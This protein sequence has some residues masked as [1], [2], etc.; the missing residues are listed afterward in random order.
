MMEPND[1]NHAVSRLK[2]RVP[3]KSRAISCWN[4]ECAWNPGTPCF[5]GCVC[6]LTVVK[7][8]LRM[9]TVNASGLETRP[10]FLTQSPSWRCVRGRL[11]MR[12]CSSHSGQ[13]SLI[14]SSAGRNLCGLLML[15]RGVRQWSKGTRLLHRSRQA[16]PSDLAVLPEKK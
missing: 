8:A 13:K 14:F 6:C 4:H 11:S 5:C 15:N 16:V 10:L 9:I 7:I 1:F 2:L 3:C 12:G